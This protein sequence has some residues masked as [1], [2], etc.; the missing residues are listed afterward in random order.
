MDRRTMSANQQQLGW[1]WALGLVLT[2]VSSAAAGTTVY[3]TEPGGIWRADTAVG[4]PAKVANLFESRGIATTDA[5]LIWTD[6]VPRVP[7]VPTGE[8]RI[9]APNGENPQYLA[10]MQPSPAG[11]DV[12]LSQERVYWSDLELNSIQYVGIQGGASPVKILAA[13]QEIS[14]IHDLVVDA[15]AGHLYFGFVNPLIDSLYPGL[16]ARINLDGSDLQF[17]ASGLLEPHGLALASDDQLLFFTD[18]ILGGGG[19]VKR[20]DLS[21]G[22]VQPIVTDLSQPRGL[23]VD[24][25]A[26]QLYWADQNKN[27]IRRSSFAGDS[28]VDVLQDLN[29]PELVSLVVTPLPGDFNSDG[30]LDAADLDEMA[31]GMVAGDVRYDLNGDGSTQFDDRLI[32]V[33]DLKRTWMGDANLDGEFNS[34]DLVAVFVAGKYETGTLATWAE[35]DWNGDTRFDSSDFVSSLQWDAGYELGPRPALAHVP[36]PASAVLL[37]VALCGLCGNRLPRTSIARARTA[38]A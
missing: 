1:M 12:D 23:A 9:A 35:G 18:G 7:I 20:L 32:W 5:H 4:N 10:E 38:A 24:P 36:E 2:G 17:L 3:W 37:L 15:P 6:M 25:V 8:V 31:V 14:R 16:I 19:A 28:V 13:Q 29:A 26:K 11:V 21:S 34:A 27:R 22:E 33:R 30:V